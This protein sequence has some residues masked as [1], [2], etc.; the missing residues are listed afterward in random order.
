MGLGRCALLLPLVLVLAASAA[1]SFGI[2]YANNCFLKDGAP[3]RYISGSIHYAR[4]PAPSWKDR[5]LK[6]YM[7]GLNAVQVYVP[8]NYHEPLPGLFN[9]ADDRDLEAFLDLTAQLGLLVILRPGPYICAEWEMGGLPAWLLWKPDIKLRSS[10]PDFLQAVDSWLDVL[11]PMIKPRLYHNGGNII[12]IKVENEYGSYYACDYDYLRHLLAAFRARLGA[13]VLL[14]TTDGNKEAA[15]RCGTL[16]GLYATVDFGPGRNVTAAFAV[17][18]LYEPKGPLVNSEYYT[19]WLDYWGQP[20]S[21]T[22]PELVASGLQ[23]ML[24]LGASVNMYMFQGG[25]N[26]GYWS[27]ADYKDKYKPVTTSY[28]Y[29]APLSEAGDPTPK[30]FAIRTVIGK[31]LGPVPSSSLPTTNTRAECCPLGSMAPASLLGARR[32]AHPPWRR[33]GCRSKQGEEKQGLVPRRSDRQGTGCR[34]HKDSPSLFQGQLWINGFNLGRFWP[35]R[36]PQQT[37]FVPGSVLSPVAP[38]NIT[39]LELQA[40]PEKAQ[41][42][43]LDRPLLNQTRS[44]PGT[45][46]A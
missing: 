46:A 4:V 15:L 13:Q 34:S 31:V 32:R 35:R 41:L 25:T 19:G 30:L 44:P 10:D 14:F 39:L 16:Q 27:G 5:L 21:S 3:F 37:L 18:R 11:L 6:M 38:N 33:G 28:D 8:W 24:K 22:D 23:D 20:H 42:L 12:S 45:G 43:F 40:A 29:D 17:Q 9:F 2:D 1:R 7:S 36:G 26:F